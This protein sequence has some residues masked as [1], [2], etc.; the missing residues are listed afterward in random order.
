MISN[1]TD[2]MATEA[3]LSDTPRDDFL[4]RWFGP[5]LETGTTACAPNLAT[6]PAFLQVD[7][8]EVPLTVNE[9][10]W[11]NSWL[12]SPYTHYITYA[13]EEITRA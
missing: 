7:G 4:C 5:L 9:K 2:P 10:E 8:I 3:T 1:T 13:H 12:C 11:D 6:M